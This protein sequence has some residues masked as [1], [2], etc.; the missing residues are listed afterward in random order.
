MHT[1]KNTDL[2][3]EK[4]LFTLDAL[5]ELSEELTSPKDFHRIMRS[6]LYMVMGNFAASKGAIF[7]FDQQKK[8]FKT[9]ATKGLSGSR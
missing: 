1:M 4:L 3:L 9:M 8:I 5:A 2:R 7:Q 6:S